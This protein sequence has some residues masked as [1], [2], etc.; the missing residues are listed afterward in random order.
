MPKFIFLLT[1]ACVPLLVS[2]QKIFL[3][4][5]LITDSTQWREGIG[6]I[7]KDVL[8]LSTKKKTLLT[9]DDVVKCQVLCDQYTQA[10]RSIDSIRHLALS[11]AQPYAGVRNVLDELYALSKAQQNKSGGGFQDIYSK[12]YKQK[13]QTLTDEEANHI[14]YDFFPLNTVSQLKENVQ[15]YLVSLEHA[16]SI[17]VEQSRELFNRYYQFIVFKE[18]FPLSRKLYGE[19]DK[20]RYIIED[21]VMVHCKSG[22]TISAVVV[23]S[24]KITTPQPAIMQFTI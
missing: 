19:D 16:D 3:P 12:L 18:V 15:Q 8:Q 13:F 22:V 20:L 17:T 2:A 10:V 4:P 7:A 21:S 11:R 1:L 6:K 9:G 24:K 23:R 5:S 14:Y